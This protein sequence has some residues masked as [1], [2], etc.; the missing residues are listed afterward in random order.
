LDS[1]DIWLPGKLSAVVVLF[2]DPAVGAVQHFLKDANIALPSLP[3]SFPR[4]P[5]R[6]R[7]EDFLKGETHFTAT[8]GLSYRRKHLSRVLPIPAELFYY[9]DDYLTVGALFEAE[10]ANI[11]QVLGMHRVHGGNWCAGG[12]EDPRKLETDFRMREV[13]SAHVRAW[14][15]ERGLKL[16]QYFEETDVLEVLR[17]KVLFESLR[18]RPDRAWGAW[19]DGAWRMKSASAL[20]TFRTATLLLAVVSPTLYLSLYLVYARTS[21]FKNLRLRLFPGR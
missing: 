16:S 13:F 18:S 19:W 10:L 21:W 17:R 8:S 3:Q 12:Y 14:L 4:W 1:D 9:L 20:A 5:A 6:Y 15:D 7:L 11:Q 2:N